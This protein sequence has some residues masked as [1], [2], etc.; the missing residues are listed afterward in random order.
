MGSI[1]FKSNKEKITKSTI[2]SF[3]DLSAKDIDGN[4]I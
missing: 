3:F 2:T 4:V 1:F